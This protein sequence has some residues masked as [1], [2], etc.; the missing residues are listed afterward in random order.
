MN[1]EQN[2]EGKEINGKSMIGFEQSQLGLWIILN[3]SQKR[4]VYQN[5]S[6]LKTLSLKLL[7]IWTQN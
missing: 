1:K 4:E 3:Q 5:I 2:N 7:H 6:Q